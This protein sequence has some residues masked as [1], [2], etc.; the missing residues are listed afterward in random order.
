MVCED[1]PSVQSTAEVTGG[2]FVNGLADHVLWVEDV[3]EAEAD[4]ARRDSKG[5]RRKGR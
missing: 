5:R 4:T 1:R 2:A 3:G